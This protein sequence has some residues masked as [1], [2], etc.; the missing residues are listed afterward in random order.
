M[1]VQPPEGRD[2]AGSRLEAS[3]GLVASGQGLL[4]WSPSEVPVPDL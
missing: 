1:A 2:V 3:P 4:S